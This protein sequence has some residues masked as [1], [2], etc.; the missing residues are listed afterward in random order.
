[1]V[2][3]A[4]LQVIMYNIGLS[5]TPDLTSIFIPP[6]DLKYLVINHKIASFTVIYFMIVPN[7]VYK[8]TFPAASLV[9]ILV[10][11]GKLQVRMMQKYFVG[12]L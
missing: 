9:G 12:F 11:K 3:G 10:C 8:K 6:P 5:I 1:M 2:S 4:C 7:L